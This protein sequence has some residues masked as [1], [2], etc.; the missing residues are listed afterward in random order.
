MCVRHSR[1]YF[2]LCH[3]SFYYLQTALAQFISYNPQYR[4]STD[5]EAVC[6]MLLFKRVC[7]V[8]LSWIP[9]HVDIMCSGVAYTA[10]AGMLVF[11][12]LL[13]AQTGILCCTYSKLNFDSFNS[14]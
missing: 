1:L 14:G 4:S 5:S 3:D 6:E 2:T 12:A 7:N 8:A 11:M 10:L 13:T 9:G